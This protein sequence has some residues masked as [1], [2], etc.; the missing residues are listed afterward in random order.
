VAITPHPLIGLASEYM[1]WK[2]LLRDFPLDGVLST[3]TR[4]NSVSLLFIRL[5]KVWTLIRLLVLSIYVQ[6]LIP[7]NQRL[8]VDLGNTIHA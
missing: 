3:T 2:A 8:L 7:Y 6:I 5:Y 4:D 1:R